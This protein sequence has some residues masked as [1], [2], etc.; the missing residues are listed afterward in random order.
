MEHEECIG[1]CGTCPAYVVNM[2]DPD[3]SEITE[4]VYQNVEGM[5]VNAS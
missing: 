5:I 1:R 3:C 4:F 2:E